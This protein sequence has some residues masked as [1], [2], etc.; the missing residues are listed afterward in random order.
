M[1]PSRNTSEMPV[2]ISSLSDA[3]LFDQVFFHFQKATAY[4]GL[5]VIMCHLHGLQEMD[6]HSADHVYLSVHLQA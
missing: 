1:K 2:F 3:C 4:N 5:N 6:A